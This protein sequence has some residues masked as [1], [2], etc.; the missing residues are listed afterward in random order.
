VNSH[1]LRVLEYRAVLSKLEPY[2]QT[3]FGKEALD[4]LVPSRNAEAIAAQLDLVWEA[5]QYLE[6]GDLRLGGAR[7]IREPVAAARRGSLIAP[8]DFLAIS[9][10]CRA[11]DGARRALAKKKETFPRLCAI[12]SGI[13]DHASLREKIEGCIGDRGEVVDSASP[14]LSKIRKELRTCHSRIQDKLNSIISSAAMGDVIQEALVTTRDGRYCIPVKSEHKSSFGGIVHDKSTSGA[15]LFMEPQS[16]VE[17]GNKYRELEIDERDEVERI[18]RELGTHVAVEADALESSIDA[19]GELDFAFARAAYSWD[20]KCVRPALNARGYL[21]L[22]DARH[23]LL[24]GD[25]VPVSISVGG[26]SRALVITGPN[27]GGKTVSLKTIGLLTLMMQSGIPVPAA[28][29]TEMSVFGKVFADIGDEQSI[30]QS[31][32]TFSSHINN[33][34]AMAKSVDSE[35]LV[36]LDEIGAGTDPAE[37]SALAKAILTFLLEKDAVAVAT[38]HYGELKEFAVVTPGVDNASVEFDIET[39][40]PTFRIRMGIPGESNAI[41]I[42]ERL[43]LRSEIVESAQRLMGEDKE[44]VERL[45]AKL[46]QGQRETEEGHL[47][48]KRRLRE[49]EES[50]AQLERRLSQQS[51]SAE[52]ALK[53]AEEKAHDMLAGAERRVEEALKELKK[54]DRTLESAKRAERALREARSELAGAVPKID[55]K[56][57]KRGPEPNIG[58]LVQL[59]AGGAIGRVLEIEGETAQ[60]AV[61]GKRLKVPVDSLILREA[62]DAVAESKGTVKIE[63]RKTVTTPLELKLIGMRADEA[64]HLVDKY[65]DDA[66]LA[67]YEKVRIIHGRGTGTLRN[68]V[69]EL[70]RASP[71]VKSFQ[72]ADRA[73]GGEGAT[74]VVFKE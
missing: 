35:S 42:A 74:M 2:V 49:L 10:F 40:Q 1:T 4:E 31:L 18:L 60:V 52:R 22:R 11:A 30:E 41:T 12:A 7:D 38:T 17:L 24:A 61:S 66:F 53:A 58:D 14:K 70:L 3:A 20:Q 9:D 65:I 59:S 34:A 51:L 54:K 44:S 33:I 73:A 27:T 13:A 56:G 8:Q 21:S 50:K 48:I 47:E 32:S 55:A 36:L 62:A 19:I 23:P 45:I 37:G 29:G 69:W 25:V 64:A 63:M 39:L 71:H 15:T 57:I 72:L 43:G 46:R 16:V 68:V 28:E 67:G 6:T 26:E 5:R